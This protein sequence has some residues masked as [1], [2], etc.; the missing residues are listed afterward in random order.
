MMPLL[1]V[2]PVEIFHHDIISWLLLI[3]AAIPGQQVQRHCDLLAVF[4]V[5]GLSD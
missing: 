3:N 4:H 2:H 5:S 1:S